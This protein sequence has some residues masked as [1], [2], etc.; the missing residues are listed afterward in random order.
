MSKIIGRLIMHRKSKTREREEEII[1]HAL[2]VEE[3]SIS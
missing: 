1:I 3:N 2:Y